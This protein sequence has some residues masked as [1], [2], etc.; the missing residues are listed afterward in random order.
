M[1]KEIE[2]WKDILGY[3]GRYQVSNLG[4]IKSL[5]RKASGALPI[6]TI[7]KISLPVQKFRYCSLSMSKD[8]IVKNHQLHTVVALHFCEKLTGKTEVNRKDG[9]KTNNKASNLEWVTSSENT[10]HGLSLGIMNTARGSQKPKC[11]KLNETKVEK[12]KKQLK[13]GVSRASIAREHGVNKVTIYAIKR[14]QTWKHV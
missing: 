14:G 11:A 2:I 10:L 13:D 5:G 1:E 4:R 12:I 6:D 8:G 3:E 7:R 9:V